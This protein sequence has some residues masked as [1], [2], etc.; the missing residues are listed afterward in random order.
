MNSNPFN[1]GWMQAVNVRER[2][3]RFLAED[4]DNVV[5]S[6]LVKIAYAISHKRI[7]FFL[8]ENHKLYYKTITDNMFYTH[9]TLYFQN[10]EIH[11]SLNNTEA[12]G[13]DRRD[14][15]FHGRIWFDTGHPE[16]NNIC[17]FWEP[18]LEVLKYW[19]YVEKLFLDNNL[20]IDEFLFEFED[21]Q[22]VD[23]KEKTWDEL[24]DSKNEFLGEI[25]IPLEIRSKVAD[26]ISKIHV[27]VGAEKEKIKTELNR[28]YKEYGRTENKKKELVAYI[29]QSF[30]KLKP[31]YGGYDTLAQGRFARRVDEEI[32]KI[33][34]RTL[35]PKLWTEN[36]KLKP[37]IRN[38]L[39]KLSQEFYSQLELKGD[40]QDIYMLGSAA[41]YNWTDKSDID[42]HILIDIAEH[43]MHPEYA[44]KMMKNISGKWNLEHDVKIKGHKVEIYIQDVREK[45]RSSAIYSIMSDEWIKEPFPEKIQVDRQEIQDKYTI[46]K[47]KIE[48]ALKQENKDLLK[49]ILKQ[50]KDYRELG[51]GSGGDLSSENIV[52]KILRH[53]GYLKRIKDC[54][55][56]L[57]DRGFSIKD[58]Y[59]PTSTGP[60]PDVGQNSNFYKT[61]ISKMRNMA[62]GDELHS[63]TPMG[64]ILR[65]PLTESGSFVKEGY[66]S[67]I[68][69]KDRL[70][71][72]NPDG[73]VRRWQIKSKDAPKTPKLDEELDSIIN[74]ILDKTFC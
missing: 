65:G 44:E 5:D 20:D 17:S 10:P 73:S 22:I 67:G 58:A 69:E 62:D 54:F 40:I 21:F 46:W 59:D 31:R 25:E 26:L 8:Y 23:G 48:D 61:H 56:N 71:I 36:K 74:E 13:F 28:I 60:N 34:N 3:S 38:S 7:I 11:K 15:I 51:L 53:R 30:K 27:T 39:L 29:K 45:N 41:S 49:S 66:G 18:K 2:N 55:N 16:Y 14:I 63:K 72:T 37:E 1:D 32:V 50:L 12:Y 57:Y 4:P 70:K 42:L 24:M 47:N 9:R 64:P 52:F 19:K 43:P 35:C 68:P 33:Y 6:T